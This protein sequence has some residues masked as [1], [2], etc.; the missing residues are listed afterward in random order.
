VDG[1]QTVVTLKEAAERLKVHQNTL[2]NWERRGLIR[3]VR[4]PGSRYRRVALEELE[5]IAREMNISLL[6]TSG[7]RLEPPPADAAAVAEGQ[8][9]VAEIK[10]Q[11][12]AREPKESNARHFRG[13]TSLTVLTPIEFL[14]AHQGQ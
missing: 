5:R 2:R 11:L 12:A 8:V 13:K 6:A 1:H 3:L 10:A 14:E 4:L 7:V 9:L